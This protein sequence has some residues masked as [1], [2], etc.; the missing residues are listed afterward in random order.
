[1]LNIVHLLLVLHIKRDRLFRWA[2]H[3]VGRF[4]S[5]RLEKEYRL[6]RIRSGPDN[7]QD[8]K[9]SERNERE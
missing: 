9:P 7:R 4:I 1:M 6:L 3:E 2:S 8:G 5:H